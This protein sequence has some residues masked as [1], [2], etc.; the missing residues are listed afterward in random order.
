MPVHVRLVGNAARLG[1]E[2]APDTFV[3]V[4]R[5]EVKRSH[6]AEIMALVLVQEDLQSWS[7]QIFL[8]VK[9]EAS[10]LLTGRCF[11]GGV[12]TVGSG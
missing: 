1:P 11:V 3:D 12:S 2:V 7:L 10:V 8:V 5:L 6:E 9:P 4:G